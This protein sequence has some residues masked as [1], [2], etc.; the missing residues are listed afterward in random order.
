MVALTAVVLRVLPVRRTIGFG[1][2]NLLGL[3]I[4]GGWQFALSAFVVTCLYWSLLRL[5]QSTSLA[6]VGAVAAIVVPVGVFIVSKIGADWT[7][8]QTWLNDHPQALVLHRILINLAYSYVFLRM[9]ELAHCVIWKEVPLVDPL[10]IAGYLF[11]FH[12]IQA[13][14]VNRYEEHVK[15]NDAAVSRDSW[16]VTLTGMD[17]VATGLIYKYVFAEY[18]RIACFGVDGRLASTAWIDTA[19]LIIYLFFDFAG[20]SRIMLGAGIW[21]GV[22]TPV[23]FKSPFAA[24]TITDFFTRWHMSLGA[25]IQRNIY[26]PLQMT[27]VR[28]WGIRRAL[29]AG[30]A[31]LLPAWAFVGLWHRFSLSCLVYGLTFAAVVALDKLIRDRVLRQSWS[32]SVAATWTARLLGPVYVFLVVTTMLHVVISEM[33]PA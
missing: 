30:L 11:P 3:T 16:L 24:A 6:K 2:W 29:W 31:A 14:P 27:L 17:Q 23:N 28:R 12:M 26:M 10:S 8:A 21:M 7:I 4:L 25:F 32:Q 13:G 15:M 5:S 19:V 1:L 33:M 22:P 18:L 9:I 20:Y